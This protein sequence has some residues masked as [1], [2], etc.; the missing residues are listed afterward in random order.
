M[1][2]MERSRV[3]LD[4]EFYISDSVPESMSFI[5]EFFRQ[6]F[7]PRND[8]DHVDFYALK[9]ADDIEEDTRAFKGLGSYYSRMPK[10]FARGALAGMVVGAAVGAIIGKPLAESCLEGMVL[11]TMVDMSQ[12]VLRGNYRYL[13]SRKENGY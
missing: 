13:K 6:E 12:Y 10:H 5:K 11:G 1:A 4:S 9:A 3:R 7:D 8:F 2:A